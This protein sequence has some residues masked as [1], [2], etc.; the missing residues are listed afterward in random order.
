M[1][2]NATLTSAFQEPLLR[3]LQE[4]LDLPALDPGQALTAGASSVARWLG[5]EKADAF[6]FD[7]QRSSLAAIGTSAT[8]LGELQRKL[9][10]D[11]LPVAQGGRS[12]EVYVT[13]R[14]HVNGHV[15][16][17]EQELR[18]IVRDLAVRSQVAVPILIAGVRRGVLSVVS[19]KPEHF[20]PDDLP[21]IE[22]VANWMSA[23][24]HRA[25]LVQ[26]LAEAERQRG[27]R[28]AADDM[29]TVLAHD[30][31]N[32]LNP[33]SARLQLL[34]LRAGR[35]ETIEAGQLDSAIRGVQRLARLSQDLL[36]SARLE[37]GL[38]ELELAPVEL[39]QLVREVADLCSTPTVEVRVEGPPQLTTI[40]DANRLRQALEN[41]IMNG[42]RYSPA[43]AQLH[44]ALEP[45]SDSQSVTIRVADRGPGIRPELLPHLFE[46]F[47]AEGSTR[48]LGLGLYLAQRVAN[49]HGGRLE[50]KSQLGVG[51]EFRL[52]LPL[53]GR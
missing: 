36:D 48:G 40:V 47:V 14:P 23:L 6:L 29:V 51:S 37:Q 19:Q 11:V 21:T 38:F 27:R 26:K 44:V 16:A 32:H 49:A 42:V 3:L 25:E 31:W 43:G 22:L 41:V 39:S 15:E 34:R 20:G 12:V 5:C 18:G 33:L 35:G 53:E 52:F 24:A 45:S 7:E 17:D 46:R 13:G 4:L 1:A 50:V 8:P 10:L 2:M 9:G 30:V 28:L